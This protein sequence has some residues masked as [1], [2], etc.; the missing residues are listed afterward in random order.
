MQQSVINS[1]QEQRI[2]GKW[3]SNLLLGSFWDSECPLVSMLL[4]AE[5]VDKDT[6]RT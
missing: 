4:E 6:I 3:V 1:A 5:T 2:V